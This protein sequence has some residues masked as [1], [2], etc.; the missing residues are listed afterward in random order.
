MLLSIVFSKGSDM[1]RTLKLLCALSIALASSHMVSGCASNEEQD[2]MRL[3]VNAAE[4]QVK[5][6]LFLGNFETTPRATI[7]NAR[8]DLKLITVRRGGTH[9]VERYAYADLMNRLSDDMGIAITARIYKCPAGKGS[10]VDNPA[11]RVKLEYDLPQPS[12]NND[13]PLFFR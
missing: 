7:E 13:D 8:Y 12:V 9:M 3:V 6:C 5:G 1:A 2:D 11:S 4:D 10:T